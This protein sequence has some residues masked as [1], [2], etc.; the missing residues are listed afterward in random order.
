MPANVWP[1]IVAIAA[2]SLVVCAVMVFS[3][4]QSLNG[5]KART[6]GDG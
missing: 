5:I 4:R 6:V 1:L 2:F 3:D